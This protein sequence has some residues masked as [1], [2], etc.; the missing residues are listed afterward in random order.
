MPKRL[1]LFA[2]VLSLL[3]ASLWYFTSRSPQPDPPTSITF[4][5][6]ADAS[7]FAHAT[8]AIPFEFPR[9]HG[10][11]FD[12]Q[13]EWW[14]YTGNLQDSAGNH[15]GYQLTFFRRGLTPGAFGAGTSPAPT[16]GLATNQ[17]YFAHFAITDVKGNTHTF[18]ERF[19]RGAGGLSGASGEPF[20][21]WLE[22][23][24]ATALDAEGSVVR[25]QARDGAMAIDLTLRAV[26]PI[27]ANGDR[28]LSVKSTEPG[29]AS[30]YLSFTRMTTQGQM[31]LNGQSTG[32]TGDS[33]FDHE[34]ST[35]ALGPR[36]VGWDWYSLQLSDGRE[37]MFYAF[38]RDDGSID[39]VSG[40]ALVEV[41]G[42][43]RQLSVDEVVIQ[44]NDTW[45]SPATGAEYP[46]QWQISIP[47][48][49]IELTVEPWI[50]GQEM[51]T[52]FVYWEGA[53]RISG[54]SDG[55][56]VSGN[57]YVELTGYAGSMQGVF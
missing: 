32:V 20:N 51:Q 3:L 10:P 24:S 12:F 57:G 40:G 27:V 5:A 25:L 47:S 26:K 14:Y 30:Y 6:D 52:T 50:A 2:L 15:Y 37:L 13:T 17:I 49:G 22:D 8:D 45:R 35:D 41:D 33:W 34:W 4:A 11:H 36:T 9:D 1:T 7:G 38:R 31:T 21:V 44:V 39:P 55:V 28:G 23:W 16:S 53:V 29:H 54:V 46:A 18:A 56:P 48:A 42:S 19:S 43:T